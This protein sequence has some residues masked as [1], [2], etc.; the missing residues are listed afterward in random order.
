MQLNLLK[1]KFKSKK[2]S[3]NFYYKKTS[4]NKFVEAFYYSVIFNSSSLT[5]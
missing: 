3:C 5:I 2:V 4:N 1:G